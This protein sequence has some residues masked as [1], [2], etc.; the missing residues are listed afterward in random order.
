MI[1]ASLN[2]IPGAQAISLQEMRTRFVLFLDRG[3]ESETIPVSK[4]PEISVFN[5]GIQC[6][7]FRQ[8]I[9]RVSSMHLLNPSLLTS[10]LC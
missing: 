1:K 2:R 6:A 8:L 10:G 4:S 5:A 7:L 9:I 3:A